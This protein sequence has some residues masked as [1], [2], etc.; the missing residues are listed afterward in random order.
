MSTRLESLAAELDALRSEIDGLDKID[1]PTE[2]QAARFAAALTEWDGKK[3]EHAV[4]K[5]ILQRM[6]DADITISFPRSESVTAA[7]RARVT[8]SSVSRSCLM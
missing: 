7:A 5:S 8:A 3:A 1:E 4:I 6:R 2:E